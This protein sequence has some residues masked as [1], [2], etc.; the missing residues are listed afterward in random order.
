MT[1]TKAAWAGRV[2]SALAVVFLA[3]DGGIKLMRVPAVLDAT[4][5]LGLPLGSI[6]PIGLTLLVC[7]LIYAIPRTQR[8]G[9]GLADRVS[10]RRRRHAGARRQPDVRD[11]LSDHRGDGGLGRGL[12]ARSPRA[13]H[14]GA[15]GAFT[16]R[17]LVAGAPD[18]R[19]ARILRER[20]VGRRALAQIERRSTRGLHPAR[21]PALRA[22]SHEASLPLSFRAVVHSDT[23]LGPDSQSFWGDGPY[24]GSGDTGYGHPPHRH[25]V[26]G[27][28][29]S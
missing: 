5:Q 9:I 11:G 19:Q 22:Q 29:R 15:S 28:R 12:S 6:V 4:V 27:G 26:D 18:D 14:A 23:L 7:T 10:R 20:G 16:L 8:R 2:L 13:G 1:G 17:G 24:C 21:V 3:F 25:P